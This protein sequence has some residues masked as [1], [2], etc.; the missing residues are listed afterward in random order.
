ML[1]YA[2]CSSNG[3][4]PEAGCSISQWAFG[5]RFDPNDGQWFAALDP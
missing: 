4:S 1:F 3:R 2:I 5:W